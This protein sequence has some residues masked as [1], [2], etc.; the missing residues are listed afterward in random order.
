MITYIYIAPFMKP[1]LG[2]PLA[3]KVG[4]LQKFEHSQCFKLFMNYKNKNNGYLY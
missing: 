1:K 4:L 2:T 3:E